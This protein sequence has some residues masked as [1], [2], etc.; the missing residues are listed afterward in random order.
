MIQTSISLH[1][2]FYY[3]RIGKRQINLWQKEIGEIVGYQEDRLLC[4]KDGK[5]HIRTLE[6]ES[7]DIFTKFV[8]P[9]PMRIPVTI[10]EWWGSLT[11]EA[12]TPNHT[13]TARTKHGRET[14]R[15]D[16][17]AG[18]SGCRQLTG[19]PLPLVRESMAVLL[20]QS[21]AKISFPRG[22]GGGFAEL[23]FRLAGR[24]DFSRLNHWHRDDSGCRLA[25]RCA[26]IPN[27]LPPKSRSCGGCR[28]WSKAYG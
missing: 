22:Q 25:P 26:G 15:Y 24:A 11:A 1:K 13:E 7:L 14:A 28:G 27:G 6:G 9:Y 20:G 3:L 10:G 18:E 5:Y 17:A 2:G 4:L 12:H 16:G 19:H 23:C 21:C 8:N